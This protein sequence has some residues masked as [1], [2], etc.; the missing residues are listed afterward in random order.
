MIPCN[1][2]LQIVDVGTFSKF[3]SNFSNFWPIF[4]LFS[5]TFG[6]KCFF[7]GAGCSS[8]CGV[9]GAIFIVMCTMNYVGGANLL[10][11]SEGATLLSIVSV[12]Y[13]IHNRKLFL[14]Y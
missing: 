2:K 11:F 12:S 7:G 9:R 13:L 1:N 10:R 14:N 6:V 8:K 5:W 3:A 4:V